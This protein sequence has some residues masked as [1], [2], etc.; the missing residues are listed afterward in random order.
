MKLWWHIYDPTIES[1]QTPESFWRNL[2]PEHLQKGIMD[3]A[4]SFAQQAFSAY[5]ENDKPSIEDIQVSMRILIASEYGWMM[6]DRPTFFIEQGIVDFVRGTK[7]EHCANVFGNV[8]IFSIAW[9]PHDRF[10]GKQLPPVLVFPANDAIV[11]Q[12]RNIDAGTLIAF[13]PKEKPLIT[14]KEE[15]TPL[16]YYLAE[17]TFGILNYLQAFPDLVK[18]GIPKSMKPRCFRHAK[19]DRVAVLAMHPKI[20]KAPKAHIRQGTWVVYSDERYKRNPD[21]SFKIG[22]RNPCIVGNIDAK[23]VE[24]QDNET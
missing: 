7:V 6:N 9:H 15:I 11:L 8:P 12:W 19:I 18:P 3:V 17:N 4:K 20:R 10:Q 16:G 14:I 21:G 22:Y 24:A 23:T 1:K 2:P 13:I 5:P